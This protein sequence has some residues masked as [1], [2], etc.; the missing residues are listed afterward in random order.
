MLFVLAVVSAFGVLFVLAVV[1][2]FGVLFVH[3]VFSA[4][5][6]VPIAIL[7]TF[8]GW[9]SESCIWVSLSHGEAPLGV[10]LRVGGVRAR[11]CRERA[12]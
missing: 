12:A 9:L 10:P 5:G 1:S 3:A 7:P 6:G 4:V 11:A 2:A 8:V